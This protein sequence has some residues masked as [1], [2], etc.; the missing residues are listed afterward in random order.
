MAV[1]PRVPS[2]RSLAAWRR[3]AIGRMTRSR[4]QTLALVA[5]LPEEAIRRPRTQGAWSIQDVLAHLA[6]WEAEGTRRLR[7][8]ARGRGDRIRFYDTRPEV[9]RFNARAVAVARRTSLAALLRT[10]AR[11]RAR[12]VG[13]LRGLPSRALAD[14]THQLPVCV[15]LREF[16]WTHEEAH[17]DAIRAW[18]GAHR[19]RSR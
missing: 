13:A 16:A 4:A 1:T 15:W 11:T 14:P 9:D 8:I 19:A 12:L 5:R 6:A 2:P 3:D 17:R 18:W 7:L 10:L